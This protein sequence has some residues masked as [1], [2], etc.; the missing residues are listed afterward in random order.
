MSEAPTGQ[1]IV[2]TIDWA[3]PAQEQ[4][5][6]YGPRPVCAS[7]G[8]GSSKTWVA[9][10]KALYL[11]D[12]YPKN[13][14]VI[15]RKVGKELRAT[16][17]ATFRKLCPPEIYSKGIWNTND[18]I[19]RL[20]NGSEILWLHLEDQEHIDIVRG[21]E[22]NFFFCDQAEEIDEGTFD[23]FQSRLGRWDQ[24]VVRQ[25]TIDRYEQHPT[26]GPRTWKWMSPAGKPLPPIYSMI[27][28]NPDTELHWIYRRFH[29]ES[30]EHLEKWKPRG[31][32]MIFFSTRENKFLSQQN[33]QQLLANDAAFVRRYV[34]GVWGI[35][36]GTIHVIPPES[37]ITFTDVAQADAFLAWVRETC[38]LHRT[39]DHGDAAP[40]VCGWFAV[41]RDGNVFCVGPETRLLTANLEWVQA[42]DVKVGDALAGFDEYARAG[43]RRRWRTSTVIA[44]QR[45]QQPSCRVFLD[46]GTSLV[47]S[48][49]HQWLVSESERNNVWK[50]TRH[51]KKGHRLIKAVDTW[52]SD[53]SWGGGYLA[54]AYDG[55]G[56]FGYTNRGTPKL[57]FTQNNNV[58]L[59]AI[60]LELEK[61]RYAFGS[62][63]CA[64]GRKTLQL[65]LNRKHDVLRLLGSCRPNRLL[66]KL[67]IDLLGGFRAIETPSVVA[68]VPIGDH[69]VVAIET[70]TGTY[71]AE[72]LASH[73][74]YREY[75]Q[76]DRL[77]SYHRQAI[78]DLSLHESYE[79]AYADPS[80]FHKAQ[81]KYGGRWCTADEYADRVNLDPR[82]AIQWWP[83]DNNEMGTR[84]RINEYLRVDPERVHPVTKQRGAP[85]LF[86]VQRTPAY[87]HGCHNITIETRA[88]KRLSLG[89]IDGMQRWSDERNPDIPDHGV[90]VLRYM[91]ASRPAIG[92]TPVPKPSRRSFRGQQALLRQQKR[93]KRALEA[94]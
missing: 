30:P 73:N 64:D 25:D 86:F 35:P 15:A 93:R 42:G 81:Q 83:A 12:E 6:T 10:L 23:L 4:F 39:L 47:C 44:T 90:D 45:T 59:E 26:K 53:R 89:T 7:G 57:T 28:C 76:A 17:M 82:T 80:I 85:R 61:R 66:Q 40:T 92:L 31:Y 41:D 65:V 8:F 48:T 84:N 21:L 1:P 79:S 19:L 62:Y 46:N 43:Q 54:A 72:G 78:A 88:Q 9:C 58:F 36:E 29:P 67:K 5:F 11:C 37:L 13:R 14:G 52:E 70:T 87:P 68:V 49:N 71:I 51:L 50:Q 55:E 33:M 75:Y 91:M 34:D 77:V 24:A 69:E 18:G 20:N 32:K 27:T 16:T 3:Q 56:S 74:C 94:Q 60:R 38:R 63:S 22:I 2:Q